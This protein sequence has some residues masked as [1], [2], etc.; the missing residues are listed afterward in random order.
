MSPCRYCQSTEFHWFSPKR[1]T[2]HGAVLMC[3]SCRRLNIELPGRR[4]VAT[5]TPIRPNLP[6][7]A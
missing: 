6:L 7:A 1:D 2:S 4:Q 5:I 3:A